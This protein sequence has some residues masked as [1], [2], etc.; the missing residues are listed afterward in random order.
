[1]HRREIDMDSTDDRKEDRGDCCGGS[2][3]CPES[4]GTGR[5]PVASGGPCCCGSQGGRG[6][7]GL[8]SIVFIVVVAAAIA[9]AVWALVKAN[10]NAADAEARGGV[11]QLAT[12]RVAVAAESK[13]VPTLADL[14]PGKDFAFV[15]LGGSN[16]DEMAAA[17]RV[18]HQALATLD[19]RGIKAAAVAVTQRDAEHKALAGAFGVDR[20]PAVVSLG[21]GGARTVAAGE[22]TEEIL[23]R[24]YVQ[25]TCG[26]SCA[27]GACGTDAS[28]QGCCPGK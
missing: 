5:E 11:D 12:A 21:S 2:P 19:K 3:C 17:T 27:P 6:A 22:I 10:R 7:F 9:V 1:M 20:L 16:S 13:G 28:A 23:L 25:A 18:V 24:D 26:T 14:A 15:I 4:P 8:R